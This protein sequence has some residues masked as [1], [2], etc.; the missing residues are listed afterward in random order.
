M[1]GNPDLHYN[2]FKTVLSKAG[3]T[4]PEETRDLIILD[5]VQI[6]REI[7]EDLDLKLRL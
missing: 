7:N 4:G 2:N 1:A 3:L 5:L 6:K